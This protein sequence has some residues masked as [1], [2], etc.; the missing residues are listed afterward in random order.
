MKIHNEIEQGSQEWL[1]LKWGKIGGTLSKGLFVKSD[2]LMID[3]LSQRLE[4]FEPTESFTSEAMDRGNEMEPFAREYIEEYYGL[5]FNVPAWLQ[6]EQN[7]LLGISPDGLTEDNKTACEIKCFGRKKHTEVLLSNEIPNDYIHQIIHYFTVNEELD[8]LI[9]IAFRPEAP[10]H[11][12]KEVT[13]ES[14]ISLGTKAKPIT[15]TVNE[16]CEIALH[17]A[18]ILLEEIK[19]HEENLKF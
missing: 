13:R 11:L 6:S 3:I 5:K 8:K 1:A 7:E 16:W 4:E 9:F 15:K 10:K 12:I 19:Q 18:N 17:E 2:T 14:E